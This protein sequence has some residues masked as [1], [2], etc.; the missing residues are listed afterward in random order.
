MVT[1][2]YELTDDTFHKYL[3]R[4]LK[5]DSEARKLAKQVFGKYYW[6]SGISYYDDEPSKYHPKGFWIKRSMTPA[7]F[8]KYKSYYK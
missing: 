5:N 3:V 6:N 2:I 4:G 7:T 1:K 8:K